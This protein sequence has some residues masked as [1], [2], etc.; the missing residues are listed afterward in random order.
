M[1]LFIAYTPACGYILVSIGSSD[2]VIMLLIGMLEGASLT[3]VPIRH[4]PPTCVTHVPIVGVL[5]LYWSSG[6]LVLYS[7]LVGV[8]LFQVLLELFVGC[9]ALPFPYPGLFL[10]PY[11]VPFL[12]GL[13]IHM[14]KSSGTTL[15]G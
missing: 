2:T 13:H 4:I 12:L 7:A 14:V 3:G 15:E 6:Q 9:S 1:P 11:L 10:V 5:F 8:G